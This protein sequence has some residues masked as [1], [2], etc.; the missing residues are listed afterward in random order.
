MSMRALLV[1][2]WT[3]WAPCKSEVSAYVLFFNFFTTKEVG[4]GTSQGLSIAHA[5]VV[6]KH[7]GTLD[8]ETE[9]GKGTTFIIRLP[10]ERKS[11]KE[12]VG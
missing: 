7:S 9:I 12:P 10:L 11:V 4:E 5:V 6:Q 2:A 8:F 3:Y 1:A